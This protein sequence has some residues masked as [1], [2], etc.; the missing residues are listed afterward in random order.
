MWFLVVST[1]G[2]R[3]E[4]D[5]T[6]HPLQWRVAMRR[7]LVT[8]GAGF[9]GSHLCA[10]LVE[11]GHQVIC[12]DN[13]QTGRV[14][15]V[16]HLLEG[17]L[18]RSFE[19]VRHDVVEPYFAEVDEI[20]HL[21]CPASPPRYQTN[22]VRTLKTAVLGTMNML[23]LARDTGARILIS[24]TSEV[25]GEPL[26]HPQREEYWGHVNPVGKRSCYDE[27]KRCG[28]A[29]AVAYAEQQGVDA[30]LVRIFNTYGP[31]MQEDDG[32][33][34]PTFI[35]QALRGEPLTVYGD[36]QQTRSLCYQSDLIEG[37]V[38]MM[39]SPDGVGP[40]N[41][42]NPTEMTVLQIAEAIRELTGSRSAIEHRPLPSDDPTRRL[43]D[44][45]RARERLGWEP[46]VSLAEG[47]AAT[48]EY[49]H[50]RL[51]ARGNGKRARARTKLALFQ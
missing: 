44:I 30:R 13:F 3:T 12:L 45:T 46:R 37:L 29:L 51:P 25:Y 47:L 48:I 17:E 7:S 22:P 33:V 5:R 19:L 32:R 18:A 38:A 10:R 35:Q 15:N 23:E 14:E 36:G 6:D 50:A 4:P 8:G 28:E 41:L 1:F 39:G 9:L 24:S 31:R 40:V 43:P 26:E 42:G 49:F 11:D 16:A 20:Y 2:D 34:V 27:G 21:A